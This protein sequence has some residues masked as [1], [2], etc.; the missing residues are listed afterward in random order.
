MDNNHQDLSPTTEDLSVSKWCHS[1]AL[2][3]L[4]LGTLPFPNSLLSHLCIMALKP[5]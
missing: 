1:V 4:W 3:T 5:L 2:D